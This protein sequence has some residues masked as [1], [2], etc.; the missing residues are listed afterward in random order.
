[1]SQKEFDD[2]IKNKLSSFSPSQS[3]GDWSSFE[4]K[5]EADDHF[6]ELI[7][8]KLQSFEV[9]FDPKSWKP[10]ARR[11]E[12]EFGWLNKV[13]RFKLVEFSFLLLV[14]YFLN[15]VPEQRVEPE[16]IV[17]HFEHTITTDI[18]DINS[19]NTDNNTPLTT[20][21]ENKF[22]PIANLPSIS[23]QAESNRIEEHLNIVPVSFTSVSIDHKAPELPNSY[24]VASYSSS[25][26]TLL[27]SN[28][29]EDL[30]SYI[31]Y[32]FF[33]GADAN[34]IVTPFDPEN[35]FDRLDRYAHGYSF[36]LTIDFHQPQYTLQTGLIISNKHYSPRQ[37]IYY[38]GSVKNGF[39][40]KRLEDINLNIL[41]VPLHLKKELISLNAWKV[42]ALAGVA[43]NVALNTD[44]QV[45]FKSS[46]GFNNYKSANL[47]NLAGSIRGK[48]L[49]EGWLEG[50][51]LKENSY[52]SFDLGIS[53]ERP[54]GKQMNWFV[55]PTYRHTNRS[56]GPGLG[57]DQD[58]I[59]TFSLY[60]GITLRFGR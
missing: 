31:A 13:F 20:N 27:V 16:P 2:I 3:K 35:R 9:P 56:L 34:R 58:I 45:Q 52:M 4:K 5:M 17:T 37:V 60:S 10:L 12:S 40:G 23:N 19:I 25:S 33:Y 43:L 51:G 54:I 6:D 44:Y 15:Q 48:Q 36:G 47:D 49:N 14:T 8:N 28:T 1:M 22:I 57:P 39:F 38:A 18:E 21:P 59:N 53:F 30:R 41:T 7:K 24:P 11:I 29:D 55:Q 46:S 32:N 42:S 26:T 50:G